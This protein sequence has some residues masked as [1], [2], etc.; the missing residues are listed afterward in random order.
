MRRYKILRADSSSAL[1]NDCSKYAAARSHPLPAAAA[2]VIDWSE[3]MLGHVAEPDGRH[4][5][6][7]DSSTSNLVSINA[8]VENTRTEMDECQNPHPPIE[9][10]PCEYLWTERDAGHSMISGLQRRGNCVSPCKIS[11]FGHARTVLLFIVAMISAALFS[12]FVYLSNW[13]IVRAAYNYRL[14]IWFAQRR[15]LCVTM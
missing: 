3:E 7:S 9:I 6:V 10:V 5:S 14:D 12:G 2:D 4:N 15:K 13:F 8:H 1:Q 11:P